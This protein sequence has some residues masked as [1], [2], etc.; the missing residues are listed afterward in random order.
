MTTETKVNPPKWFWIVSVLALLWNVMGVFAYLAQAFMSIEALEA[1]SQAERALYESQ[2]AWVTAAFAIA[3]WAGLL[4]C[5]LLLIRKK[6]AK[7]V[8]VISLLGVLAQTTYNFFL[9]NTFEVYGT[10]AM[11]MPI[12]ILVVS[13]LLVLFSNRAID[14]NWLS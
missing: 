10:G 13:V 5:I 8:F 14:K 12:M 9:S 11:A 7:T 1:M 4:G 6:L 2:P 3:V